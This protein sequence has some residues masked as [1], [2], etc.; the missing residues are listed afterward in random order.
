MGSLD[1]S[2]AFDLDDFMAREDEEDESLAGDLAR[3]GVAALSGGRVN[4]SSVGVLRPGGAQGG[5]K[6][7]TPISLLPSGGVAPST[8]TSAVSSSRSQNALTALG[9][10][11]DPAKPFNLLQA[12]RA[13]SGRGGTVSSGGGMKD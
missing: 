8:T 6:L 4:G 13:S 1:A 7:P 10:A 2:H 9:G 3:G 11:R 12:G 5:N